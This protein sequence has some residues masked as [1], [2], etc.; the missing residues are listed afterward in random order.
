MT[1]VSTRNR[2]TLDVPAYNEDSWCPRRTHMGTTI[3]RNTCRKLSY[4]S[5]SCHGLQ[6]QFAEQQSHNEE[7]S[8]ITTDSSPRHMQILMHEKNT[9]P[10]HCARSSTSLSSW[11]S[12][13]SVKSV[14]TEEGPEIL[15]PTKKYSTQTYSVE[16]INYP[17]LHQ[18]GI[19]DISESS[20]SDDQ[21]HNR[22][23]Y[24]DES[25]RMTG[26]TKLLTPNTPSTQ[27]SSLADESME[28]LPLGITD[29]YAPSVSNNNVE[30]ATNYQAQCRSY[31]VPTRI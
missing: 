31:Y 2:D 1:L 13:R 11:I 23:R 29:D 17:S 6:H 21:T 30:P 20:S 7:M 28:E 22:N 26:R 14:L 9:G 25:S 18:K 10:S 16:G 27:N 4:S 8:V 15:K 5:D 12:S 19:D 3:D 24:R